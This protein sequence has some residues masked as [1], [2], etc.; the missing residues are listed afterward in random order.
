MV[1]TPPSMDLPIS[2]VHTLPI[3]LLLLGQLL[4]ETGGLLCALLLAL[5][6]RF[7][8][9]PHTGQ[10]LL[11]LLQLLLQLLGD[12]VQLLPLCLPWEE[13]ALTQASPCPGCRLLPV[14]LHPQHTRLWP[15]LELSES[16]PGVPCS[17]ARPTSCWMMWALSCSSASR[18]FRSS[19]NCSNSRLTSIAGGGGGQLRQ[20]EKQSQRNSPTCLTLKSSLL[21]PHC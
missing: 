19:R 2:P 4:P 7:Q 3:D 18:R 11:G 16:G 5:A 1:P 14:S 15:L 17:R 8:L 21:G 10:G 12:L 9:Q 6:S 20:E 13:E